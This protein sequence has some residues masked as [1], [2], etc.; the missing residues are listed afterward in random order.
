MADW[1]SAALDK[2][3]PEINGLI[4]DFNAGVNTRIKKEALLEDIMKM[5]SG[6]NLAYVTRKANASVWV[7]MCNRFGAGLDTKDVNDLLYKIVTEKGWSTLACVKARAFEREP[8][9]TEQY[10]FN[11]KLV[12]A[13]DGYLAPVDPHEPN[14]FYRFH[15]AIQSQAC[16]LWLLA[17][18]ATTSSL[19]STVCSTR[20][21]SWTC[22]RR[23]GHRWTTGWSGPS[24]GRL[25][26]SGAHTLQRL[27]SLRATPTTERRE[28]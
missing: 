19:L 20:R 7:D 28:R 2:V 14:I 27:R 9:E 17:A 5:L 4:D 21:R 16:A 18:R 24:F 15:A 12:E 25:C 26:G 11:L 10:Q 3:C 13:S 8:G 1:M 23:C 6:A 22:P